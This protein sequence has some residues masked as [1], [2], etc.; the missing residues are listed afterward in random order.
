MAA[1]V[2]WKFELTYF[3]MD[4]YAD[5]TAEVEEPNRIVTGKLNYY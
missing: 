3:D 1:G 2:T 4:T 5:V